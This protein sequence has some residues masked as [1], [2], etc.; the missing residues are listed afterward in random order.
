MIAL[1][2]ETGST[3]WETDRP[4]MDAPTGDQ[5][6]AYCTPIVVT[7]SNGREQLLC[8]GS[9]WMVSYNAKRAKSFGVSIMAKDSL[10]F[11]APS[12]MAMRS[13]SRPGLANHNSGRQGRW[14]R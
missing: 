3:E 11:L 10:L 14:F 5:K 7:D 9:Q 1:N 12:S 13:T 4:P 2:A 6:K 8:M